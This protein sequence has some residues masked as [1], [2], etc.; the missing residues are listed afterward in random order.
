[1]SSII[2]SDGAL[3]PTY[4][5]IFGPVFWG[6]CA[7]LVLCGVSTLQG[8]LYFTRYNDRTGIQVVAGIMLFLDFLS[9]GLICQSMYYYMLPHY[10]SLGPLSAVTRELS[11]ECLIS[12]IITFISQMYFVYQLRIGES[13]LLKS[14]GRAAWVMI[15]MTII[16][17]A[18]SLAGGVGCVAIMFTHPHS[19][20]MNRNRAFIILA[21]INKAFGAAADIV[22]T[23]AMCLFLTG[24]ETGIKR[25]SSLLRSLI[26]LVIN[27]GLL[28]T[29]AQILMLVLFFAST[30]HLYWLAVHI[31]T[32]KL[33]VNTFFAMLNARTSY[34]DTVSGPHIS[35]GGLSSAR[36]ATVVH[37]ASVDEV[38]KFS[39]MNHNS[40]TMDAI[41][42]TTT[43]TVADI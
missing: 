22:A 2:S 36:S 32:T 8:Y 3:G 14:G 34:L 39:G 16:L 35:M 13:M 17:G 26:H 31:N 41:K 27:R 24:A 25:T 20:L 40:Y 6:F 42:V 18:A 4:V 30:T 23:I 19:I 43:S 11:V 9:M 29:F 12:A 7:T 10:G 37:T 28:V 21:G 1:M 5:E 38:K 33:Y 15:H